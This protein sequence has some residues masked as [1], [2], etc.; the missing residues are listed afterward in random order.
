MEL[1]YES[2]NIQEIN[3]CATFTGLYE[4]HTHLSLPNIEK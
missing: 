3:D 4:F 1:T 2:Q